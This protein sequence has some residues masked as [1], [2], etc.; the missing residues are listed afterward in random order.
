MRGLSVS[1]LL[2]ALLF[3]AGCGSGGGGGGSSQ[4]SGEASKSANQILED[5]VKAAEAASSVHVAGR[6]ATSGKQVGLDLSLARNKGAA[7]SLTLNGAKI[8]LV[9]VGK[10][11]YMRAGPAFWKK[12]GGASGFAQIFAGKWLKF[13][14][15]NAQLGSLTGVANEKSLFDNLAS[16][17]KLE[18]QGATTYQGQSVVAIHDTK[19]NATLYVSASGTPYPV[20]I[21]KTNHPTAGA[22]T[23]DRWNQSVTLTAPKGA[24]DFSHFGSG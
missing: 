20:A 4:S 16:H 13:P 12:Y 1:A 11:G 22:I 7:G 2:V 10:T 8:D 21:V 23:F 3:A 17:G 18:N 9:L 15:N 5:A 6:V 14:A 19:K 24:L